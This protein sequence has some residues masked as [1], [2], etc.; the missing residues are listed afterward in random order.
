MS[1]F[2]CPK[3]GKHSESKVTDCRTAPNANAWRRRRECLACGQR[4][5]TIEVIAPEGRRGYG[6][7]ISIDYCSNID[8]VNNPERRRGSVS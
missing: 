4:Y 5:S 1:Y 3:C 7:T 8:S 6:Y 2:L